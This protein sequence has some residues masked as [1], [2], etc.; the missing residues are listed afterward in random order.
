MPTPQQIE[1]YER[2]RAKAN[3]AL[4]KEAKQQRDA[5]KLEKET[6]KENK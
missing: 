3:E 2:D 6:R 5:R 1:K 4:A